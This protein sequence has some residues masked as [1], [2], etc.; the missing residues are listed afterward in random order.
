MV[1]ILLVICFLVLGVVRG[2]D[3]I[4]K[5]LEEHNASTN[6]KLLIDLCRRQYELIDRL[7]IKVHNIE[8]EFTTSGPKKIEAEEFTAM[9]MTLE[10]IAT[11][12]EVVERIAISKS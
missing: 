7:Y 9:W 8:T 10:R 4:R 6:I 1:W 2:L 5:K 11:S 3:D 12:V